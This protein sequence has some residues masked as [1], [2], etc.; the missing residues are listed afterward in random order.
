MCRLGRRFTEIVLARGTI[1][2]SEDS[3][4]HC[5]ILVRVEVNDAESLLKRTSGNHHVLVYGDYVSQ[6]RKLSHILGLRVVEL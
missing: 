5:R 2:R 3:S 4:K 6:M 1:L